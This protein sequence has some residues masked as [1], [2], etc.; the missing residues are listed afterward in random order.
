MKAA[1]ALLVLLGAGGWCLLRRREGMLPV[2]LG[3]AL[4][5]D[6]AVLEYQV[7]VC[8]TPLPELLE[9]L[10]AGLG[11]QWLWTPLLEQ[12][13]EEREPLPQCWRRAA[14]ALPPPLDRLLVPLGET[15]PAGGERLRAAVEETREEMSRFL[16][17]EAARQASQGRITAA[18]CLSAACLV[19]LVL[20]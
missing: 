8:R 2:R 17:E 5:E 7:R 9:G 13:R 10:S 15:L 16:R 6:L 19:I 18:L 12:V 3:Q 20:L 4:L 1:G 11:A 14:A